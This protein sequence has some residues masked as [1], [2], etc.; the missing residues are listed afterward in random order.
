MKTEDYYNQTPLLSNEQAVLK[1]FSLIE[2]HVSVLFQNKHPF[3]SRHSGE[4]ERFYGSASIKQHV[5]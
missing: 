5:L 4:N 3:S 2:M 1:S